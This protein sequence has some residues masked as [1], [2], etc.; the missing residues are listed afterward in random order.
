MTPSILNVFQK[1]SAT[2]TVAGPGVQ[3]L[4]EMVAVLKN[5]LPVPGV[6][7]QLV[8]SSVD[9][10]QLKIS[11]AANAVPTKDCTLQFIDSNDGYRLNLDA[12]IGRVNVYAYQLPV[13]YEPWG[14]CRWY[15]G[16]QVRI[17]GKGNPGQ[18]Y[19]FRLLPNYTNIPR[20]MPDAN[21]DILI[22]FVPS[23][24]LPDSDQYTL[25]MYTTGVGGPDYHKIVSPN[26]S[27]RHEILTPNITS[28]SRSVPSNLTIRQR[29]DI[30]GTN[31][32]PRSAWTETARVLLDYG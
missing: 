3:R 25:E 13:L 31:L 4:M 16:S 6:T 12:A 18:L 1:S 7:A 20:A 10:R 17:R 15:A 32:S 2:A 27:I 26:F 22:P 14:G 24:N 30:K 28:V 19:E 23:G 11:A 29:I 5:G 9:T 8:W 21:G